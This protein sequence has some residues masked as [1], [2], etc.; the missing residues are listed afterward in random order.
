[1][2]DGPAVA[3]L[4]QPPDHVD[5]VAVERVQASLCSG[6]KDRDLAT[7]I[8]APGVDVHASSMP[9]PAAFQDFAAAYTADGSEPSNRRTSASG[10]TP[11]RPTSVG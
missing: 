5:P 10:S 3:D 8:V 6:G 7:P 1:M 4:E 9:R 11:A 2:E